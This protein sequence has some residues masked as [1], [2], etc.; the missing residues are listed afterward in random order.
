[1]G[2]LN[3]GLSYIEKAYVFEA[4]Y[5]FCTLLYDISV[6]LFVCKEKMLYKG[7]VDFSFLRKYVVIQYNLL[8]YGDI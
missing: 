4:F 1:M 3:T 5:L 6:C 2:Y 8:F 7:N